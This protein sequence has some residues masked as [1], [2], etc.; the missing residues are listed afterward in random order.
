MEAWLVIASNLAAH[1]G[2]DVMLLDNQV[3][4]HRTFSGPCVRICGRRVAKRGRTSRAVMSMRIIGPFLVLVASKTG[5]SRRSTRRGEGCDE[6]VALD[7]FLFL[8][9]AILLGPVRGQS[10]LRLGRWQSLPA[11]PPLDTNSG[12]RSTDSAKLCSWA[13]LGIL[14][15]GHLC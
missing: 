8:E 12:E 4:S 15:L 5:C 6:I 2:S 1:N 9:S 14:E 7:L 13:Y 10:S 11:C 3:D